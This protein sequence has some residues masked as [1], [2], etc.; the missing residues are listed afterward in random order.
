MNIN[1]LRQQVLTQDHS[2]IVIFSDINIR[3]LSHFSGHAATLLITNKAH[4]L[5]TDYRYFEQAK[6]QCDD[7]QVICLLMPCCWRSHIRKEQAR[8]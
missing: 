7:F 4:Y 1:T 3:Y 5:I 8:Y 2:A 6:A